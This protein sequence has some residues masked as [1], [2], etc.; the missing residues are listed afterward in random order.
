MLS[1]QAGHHLGYHDL[2]IRAYSG[3]R[4]Q[5]PGVRS[6]ATMREDGTRAY[7]RPMHTER[8]DKP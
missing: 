2:R 3:G 8:I 4:I 1:K 6:P 5:R 7:S